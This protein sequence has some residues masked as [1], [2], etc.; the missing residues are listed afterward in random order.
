M[1]KL[2]LKGFSIVLIGAFVMSSYISWC[3]YGLY[4]SVKGDS[5]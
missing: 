1:S 2:V 4:R 3:S 5:E